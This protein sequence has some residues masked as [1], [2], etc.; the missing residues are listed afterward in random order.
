MW[1]EN[2][3]VITGQGKRGEESSEAESIPG[4]AERAEGAECSQ[5]SPSPAHNLAAVSPQNKISQCGG[6]W[7]EG[8]ASV[9]V[10]LPALPK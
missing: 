3:V 6:V 8:C 5:E 1:I 2:L 7:E 10:V 4:A 9:E